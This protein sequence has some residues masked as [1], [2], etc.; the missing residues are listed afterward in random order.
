MPSSKTPMTRVKLFLVVLGIILGFAALELGFRLLPLRSDGFRVTIASQQWFKRYWGSPNRWGFRDAEHSAELLAR[1]Q[2]LFVVG[3]SFV[4]GSGIARRQDR[5]SDLIDRRFP[6][7]LVLNFARA[8]WSTR[9]ELQALRSFTPQPEAILLSYY[10]NDIQG[11]ARSH[12]K[13]LNLNTS[14]PHMLAPLIESSHAFNFVYW[15]YW[16]L[17]DLAKGYY[18]LLIDSFQDEAIWQ[19]HLHEISEVVKWAEEHSHLAGAIVFPDLL[20]I[21]RFRTQTRQ[22]VE[23]LR[24]SG[25]PVVNLADH[26]EGR[27]PSTLIVNALNPHP[28]ESLHRDVADLLIPIL[29][30]NLPN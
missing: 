12:G 18:K 22:V 2:T 28:N 17:P 23:V 16:R 7:W 24:E 30:K 19:T 26:L 6:D 15:R 27:D 11:A 21:E 14:P 4:A 3:D 1:S 10:I 8:G 25:I 5:F 9:D 13:Q 20:D 29:S